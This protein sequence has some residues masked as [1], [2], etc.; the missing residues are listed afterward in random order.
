MILTPQLQ[1]D[2]VKQC[3]KFQKELAGKNVLTTNAIPEFTDI[4]IRTTDAIW[5]FGERYECSDQG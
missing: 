4:I 5:M 2:R 1:A 3:W